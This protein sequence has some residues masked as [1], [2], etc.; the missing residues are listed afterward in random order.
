MVMTKRRD[1]VKM[2][3]EAATA[4][5]IPFEVARQG[6]RHTVDNLGGKHI[7]IARHNEI[8]NQMAEVILNKTPTYLERSGGSDQGAPRAYAPRDGRFWVIEVPETGQT[9]QARTT[10]DA[11]AMA[12]DLISVMLDVP[13]N[14]YAVSMHCVLPAGVVEHLDRAERLRN[15]AAHANSAAAADVRRAAAEL[16]DSGLALLDIGRVMGVTYQ[17]AGQLVNP[18]SKPL[19]RDYALSSVSRKSNLGCR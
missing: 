15:E 16:R 2:I 3:R 19:Q 7:P 4:A 13:P 17:R 14:T 5:G 18:T 12:R 1:L 6:S 9:T 11:E 10:A 8:A